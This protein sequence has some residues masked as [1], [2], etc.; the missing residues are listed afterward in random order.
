MNNPS[1]VI[2]GAAAKCNRR[3]VFLVD[4]G[5]CENFNDSVMRIIYLVYTSEKHVYDHVVIIIIIIIGNLSLI[6]FRVH[7]VVR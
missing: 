4:N 5:P 3:N 2:A 6:H 7:D 1:A